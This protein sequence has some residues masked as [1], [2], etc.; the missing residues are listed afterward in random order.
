MAIYL[1][2]ERQRTLLYYDLYL[3]LKNHLRQNVAKKICLK[4][5]AFSQP[6]WTKK[7]VFPATFFI[8]QPCQKE[9]LRK[10]Y[11]VFHI[12]GH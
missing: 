8:L 12:S 1:F 5:H 6:L 10:S 3:F 4:I 9:S 11:R 7:I 2:I